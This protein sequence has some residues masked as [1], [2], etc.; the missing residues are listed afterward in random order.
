[1]STIETWSVPRLWAG[2]RCFIICGGDSVKAQRAQVP[3]LKGRVIAVKHSI[4]LR[5]DADVF[6]VSGE[7]T[8]DAVTQLMP[9]VRAEHHVVRGRHLQ[10]LPDSFKRVG[11]DKDHT[12]LCEDPTR[13][14]G[15]DTGTSAI[16]LAYHLGATEVVLLGY[17]MTGGHWFNGELKHPKPFPPDGD[18]QRHMA[19]LHGLAEDCRVKGI[20][21]VNVSPISRVEAFERGRLEDFL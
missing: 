4:V 6:F 21:V 16:N 5:P 20:R 10:D 9:H 2:E 7:R 13:V 3:Q 8:Q 11:R 19:P 14:S 1:M 17:D 15:Y 18:F 12:R